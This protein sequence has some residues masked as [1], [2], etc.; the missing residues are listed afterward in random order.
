MTK[1]YITGLHI[2]TLILMWGLLLA[3]QTAHAQKAEA[4]LS[5][6]IRN[7]TLE[8]FV[9][10]LENS[11]GFSFIYG[12]EVKINRRITLNVEQKTLKEI[13]NLAFANEPVSYQISGKHILLQKKKQK[14]ASR[15]F[16]ISGYV[17]DEASSETLIGANI[18]ESRQRQ[19]TT[20]NPYGFYSLTLPEGETELAFSY[21][22][23]ETQRYNI[24]LEKDTLINIR[25]RDNN[26][27][28]EV[29]IVSNKTEAGVTATQM[30]A[31][32]IPM[33]QI[34]NTPSILG[35]ADVMKTIQLMPVWK[36][37]PGFTFAEEARIRTLFFWMACLF[38]M[39][40]TCS[41]FFPSSLPKQ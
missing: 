8:E 35:E 10:R 25:M 41:V 29:V 19:G 24:A 11:T 27:L 4:R 39:S 28:E 38:I 23:Y 15:K 34:K 14:P 30:G 9:K 26:Q 33:A 20:T 1:H 21:L 16:T 6:S 12:E 22:G 37:P 18:L 36:V 13:L 5:F 32:E 31:I 7:A 3:L 40:T 2:R 17:T